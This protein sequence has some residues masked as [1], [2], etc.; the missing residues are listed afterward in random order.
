MVSG[1]AWYIRVRIH[2]VHPVEDF[3]P[4]PLRV[5]VIVIAVAHEHGRHAVAVATLLRTRRVRVEHP[6]G[7]IEPFLSPIHAPGQ[8]C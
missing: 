3:L 4:R 5:F 7:I 8:L 1:R 6:A 2:L